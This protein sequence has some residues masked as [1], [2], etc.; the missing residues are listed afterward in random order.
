VQAGAPKT[1]PVGHIA[2]TRLASIGSGRKV[3]L[4]TAK[5]TR[6]ELRKLAE[7]AEAGKLRPVI[8]RQHHL[9]ELA[10]ALAC[11]GQGHTRGKVVVTV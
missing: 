10:Q 3:V 9:G 2:T 6:P 7:L 1:N 5:P 11:V 8:E 4:F